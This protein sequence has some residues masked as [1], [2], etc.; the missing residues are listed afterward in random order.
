MHVIQFVDA[1]DAVLVERQVSSRDQGFAAFDRATRETPPD[2]AVAVVMR[3]DGRIHRRAPVREVVHVE[4]RK[5]S[6]AADH[7]RERA[8]DEA[9]DQGGGAPVPEPAADRKAKTKRPG[10]G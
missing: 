2:G 5:A 7:V 9:V 1:E 3:D 6:A 4:T 8:G 10:R